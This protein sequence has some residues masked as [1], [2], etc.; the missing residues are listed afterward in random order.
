VTPHARPSAVGLDARHFRKVA[1]GGFGDPANSYAFSMAWFRDALYVGT[2]RNMLALVQSSPPREPAAMNPWPV[3]VPESVFSLDLRAQLWRYSPESD[4]W[5]C[6]FTSPLVP[7]PDGQQTP[8][9]IGYRHM[10][11]FK[12]P[13]ERY[14]RL[15][16]ATASSNTRGP[17]AYILRYDGDELSPVSRPGLGDQQVS[18]FRTISSFDGLL[19]SAPTGS[20][21]AWN[22]ADAPAI[23]ATPDPLAEDWRAISSSGFGSEANQAVYA[24]TA[25]NGHLY[26]GTLNPFTGYEIWK[27]D[28]GRS[29]DERWRRIVAGGAGRGNLNEAAMTMCVFGEALY[30]GS[31]ISNGGYDRTHGV[32]PGAGEVI[33]IHPDDSWELVVGEARVGSRGPRTP[34]SGL[35]PGFGNP[36][37]GYI[38]SMAVHDGHLYVG[39]FDST[40][41]ALWAD[42][43]R[44][45]LERQLK[46]RQLGVER[47]VERNAGFDLFRTRDGVTWTAVTQNGFGNPYNYGARNLV[48]TPAGLFVGTANPFGPN[49]AARLAHGW[50]YVP[51]PRGGLEIWCGSVDDGGEARAAEHA[52]ATGRERLTLPAARGRV[53]RHGRPRAAHVEARERQMFSP[54]GDELYGGSDFWGI[55]YWDGATRSL[56][57]AAEN[58]VEQLLALMP[59]NTG[60]ILDVGCGKGATARYLTRYYEP[61]DVV[62]IALS[63]RQLAAS[64]RNAPR[65][66]FLELDPVDLRLPSESFDAVVSIEA[67]Y[68]FDTREDFL[69]EA[70]RVLRPGGELALADL[71]TRILPR[72]AERVR[73][74]NH[75]DSTASY[76]RLL[77]EVGFSDVIVRDVTQETVVGY[78][79]YV[80]ELV[81]AKL[82]LR[83]IDRRTRALLLLGLRRR[84]A[85]VRSYVLVGARKR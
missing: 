19:C 7:G 53:R 84:C 57:A 17:G 78:A 27:L 81:E 58:L 64:R 13:S 15:Y 75:L 16:V 69:R 29:G 47:F 41:F 31:G 33:R 28:L 23:Y 18:T 59:G 50:E 44:Q 61:E 39:T 70:Y 65:C 52:T 40:I 38:W 82:R 30:V 83:Q 34:L 8:R 48:S 2:A 43:R 6:A 54:L 11:L 67:A 22:A 71:L 37:N 76:A 5:D 24:M 63:A 32:G 49:V 80:A 62:G 51:N 72:R 3:D 85:G 1:G 68:R 74:S 26:A 79:R 60:R 20:G 45:P 55:G 56:H 4:A 66:V 73:R 36:F 10:T 42:L 77:R 9:E 35:G 46:L 14:A 12:R 25:F 21:R